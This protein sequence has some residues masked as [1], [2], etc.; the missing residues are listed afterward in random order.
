MC[1]LSQTCECLVSFAGSN[2]AHFIL[3]GSFSLSYTE[4]LLHC[5]RQMLLSSIECKPN[6][7]FSS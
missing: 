5:V 1:S 4:Q 6:F 2:L 7:D 3:V